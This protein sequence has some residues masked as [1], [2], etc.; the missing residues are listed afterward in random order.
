M[1]PNILE[2]LLDDGMREVTFGGLTSCLQ[3]ELLEV[4]SSLLPKIHLI[5]SFLTEFL[6]RQLKECEKEVVERL[7]PVTA[8]W[9]EVELIESLSQGVADRLELAVRP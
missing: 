4:L 1:E 8:V 6:N 7:N 5:P 9:E 3:D 2:A